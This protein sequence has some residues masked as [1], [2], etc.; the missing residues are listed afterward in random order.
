ME[1]ALVSW[2]LFICSLLIAYCNQYKYAKTQNSLLDFVFHFPCSAT[3]IFLF[4][5]NERSQI[6][7]SSICR[8]FTVPFSTLIKQ[9]N[10][11]YRD[12]PLCFLSSD[13]FIRIS[14]F[15]ILNLKFDPI[16]FQIHYSFKPLRAF[17]RS[18][19]DHFDQKKTF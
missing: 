4:K 12:E 3:T 18:K 9:S 15:R 16:R 19:N 17:L 10:I 11:E 5:S 2:R 13:E 14:F 6:K 7:S 1:I 8:K